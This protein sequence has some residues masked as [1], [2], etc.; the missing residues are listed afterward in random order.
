MALGRIGD[1]KATLALV[2]ALDDPELA[3]PVAGALARLGD[4]DAF[5]ALMGL[6]GHADSAVRQAAIAA[7]NS[8]GHPDMPARI[9]GLLADPNRGRSRIGGENRRLLRL[10][11]VRRSRHRLRQGHQRGGAARDRGASAF[12][13]APGRPSRAQARTGVRHACS[14]RGRC[15]GVRTRGRRRRGGAHSES[16]RGRRALGPV[17][18]LARGRPAAA[19]A[20]RPGGTAAARSRP[21]AAGA[22]RGHRRARTPRHA[23]RRGDPAAPHHGCGRRRGPRGDSRPGAHERCAR[24]GRPLETCYGRRIRHAG[25]KR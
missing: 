13:R 2:A 17:L 14:A 20:D 11:R 7:L 12:V 22:P 16:A 3:L 25:S 24:R 5:D 15:G 23:R 8:I 19:R 21:G 9:D 10:R 18:R 6:L 4:A 1:R